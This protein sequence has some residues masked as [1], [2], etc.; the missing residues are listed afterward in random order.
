MLPGSN[1][2]KGVKHLQAVGEGDADVIVRALRPREVEQ[3]EYGHVLQDIL[4]LATA[5]R[6][7]NFTH[8]KCLGNSVAHFLV[9]CKKGLD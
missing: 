8:V 5:F 1:L 4:V 6:V 2:C 9:K 7:C 3:P